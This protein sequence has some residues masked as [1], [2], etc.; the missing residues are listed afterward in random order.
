MS[1]QESFSREEV[2]SMLT[3]LFKVVTSRLTG[4]AY[5]PSWEGNTNEPQTSNGCMYSTL[6][7][8][9]MSVIETSLDKERA[10]SAKI[11]LRQLF[12]GTVSE[13]HS[14]LCEAFETTITNDQTIGF[15]ALWED[16]KKKLN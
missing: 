3:D 8:Q 7:A 4:S 1:K 13:E 15:G 2:V 5:F 9:S 6:R 10:E 16:I 12:Q 11:I 14:T